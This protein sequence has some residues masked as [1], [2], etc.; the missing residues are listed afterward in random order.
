[1][2]RA[3]VPSMQHIGN[4]VNVGQFPQI[5]N[6]SSSDSDLLIA[7]SSRSVSRAL[8]A[9]LFYL[10]I[11][12]LLVWFGLVAQAGLE[13]IIFLLQLPLYWDYRYLPLCL[14]WFSYTPS[15]YPF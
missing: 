4:Q 1:M 3:W 15:Q 5:R 14:D 11:Y 13:L 12:S 6:D 2:Q 10:E 8:L 7:F 9:D